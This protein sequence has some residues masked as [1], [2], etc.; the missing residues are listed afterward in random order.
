LNWHQWAFLPI[1]GGAHWK[2][3]EA[4]DYDAN[5]CVSLG[6]DQPFAPLHGDN[7]N[8]G[9]GWGMFRV[10]VWPNS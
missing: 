4:N 5:G 9:W 10:V 3:Y 2:D 1:R 8:P 7:D 6:P